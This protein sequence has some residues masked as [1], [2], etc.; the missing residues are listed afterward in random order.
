MRKKAQG[1]MT[2]TEL[3]GKRFQGNVARSLE[4]E[5]VTFRSSGEVMGR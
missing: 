1:G 5:K 2:G 3:I 4:G